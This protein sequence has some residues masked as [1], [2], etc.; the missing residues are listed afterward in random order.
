MSEGCH[1]QFLRL[2]RPAKGQCGL[3]KPNAKKGLF[4][5]PHLPWKPGM[6]PP[7]LGK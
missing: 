6:L 7:T 1:G 2:Q 4:C 5:A 3:A